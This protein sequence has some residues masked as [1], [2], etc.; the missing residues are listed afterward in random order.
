MATQYIIR[1]P[2][3]AVHNGDH[4]CMDTV[5]IS[6]NAANWS[7]AVDPAANGGA[8]DVYRC[9]RAFVPNY[10]GTLVFQAAQDSADS[11]MIVNAGQV[12]PIA[13]KSITQASCSAALQVANAICALY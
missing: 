11:T 6:L 3:N 7:T 8:G 1:A 2:Q 4:P 5:M 9:P 10:S 13:I 12:Y